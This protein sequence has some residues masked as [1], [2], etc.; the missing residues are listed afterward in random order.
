[1]DFDKVENVEEVNIFEG[2]YGYSK[3]IKENSYV[4]MKEC[5]EWLECCNWNCIE[6][7]LEF[8][9][10]IGIKKKERVVKDL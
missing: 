4:G 9:L 2:V 5:E 8:D 7:G 10:E 6:R 1:M 3:E